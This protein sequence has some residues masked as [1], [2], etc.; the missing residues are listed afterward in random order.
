MNVNAIVVRTFNE[1][2]D[3]MLRR[4]N[5]E[6]HKNQALREFRAHEQFTPRSERRRTKSARARSRQRKA[7]GQVE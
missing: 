7:G 3:N 5:K 6:L 4:L 1:P 2:V